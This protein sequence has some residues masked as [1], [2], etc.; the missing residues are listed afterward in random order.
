L[1]VAGT[2]TVYTYTVVRHAVVPILAEAVPYVV[3]AVDLD[4]AG[5]RM[6]ANLVGCDPEAVHIGS[7]VAV[8][9]DDIDL[10]DPT[11]APP[12]D[13]VAEFGDHVTIPR[14]RLISDGSDSER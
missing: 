14:F 8:H 4:E 11:D 3:A 7:R 1:D 13:G 10:A 6:V 9:W 2:G 12:P 5:V